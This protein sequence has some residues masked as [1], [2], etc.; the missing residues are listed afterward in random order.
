[1]IGKAFAYRTVAV[2]LLAAIAGCGGGDGPRSYTVTA[3]AGPGGSVSP[4]SATVPEGASTSIAIALNEGYEIAEVTGCGGTLSQTTYTTA[5]VISACSISAIFR[6]KR[7]AVTAT[8]N[9]GGSIIPASAMIEHGSRATF[10][11]AAQVGHEVVN[12]AGCGGTLSGLT[13]TTGILTGPCTVTVEYRRIPLFS[14]AATLLPDL[15]DHYLS[16]CANRTQGPLELKRDQPNM[17][18]GT[19]ANFSGHK[20]G[21]KDLAFTMW[22]G[23]PGGMEISGPTPNGGVVFQQDKNGNFSDATRKMF[24]VD[25][26]ET[27]EGVA[28]KPVVWDANGDGYDEVVWPVQGE[29]GRA[30][31]PV[32]RRF[33]FLTSQAGGLYERTLKGSLKENAGWVTLYPNEIGSF[34]V[35]TTDTVW[36]WSS[37]WQESAGFSWYKIGTTFLAR[38]AGEARSTL[39]TRPSGPTL[40][41]GPSIGLWRHDATTGWRETHFF[42]F[43][44]RSVPFITWRK[45]QGTIDLF[46]IDGRQYIYGNFERNCELSDT[47]AGE[48]RLF[49]LF[50]ASRLDLPYQEGSTLI[51]GQGTT[52]VVIPVL[53]DLSDGRLSRVSAVFKGWDEEVAPFDLACDDLDGDGNRD[54]LIFPGDDVKER[55]RP[56]VY[57]NISKDSFAAVDRSFFPTPIP[58]MRFATALYQDIDGDGFRDLVYWPLNINRIVAGQSLR[59]PLHKGRRNVSRDDL[60]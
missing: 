31:Q 50:N 28:W 6:L 55:A 34:D 43:P 32:Y 11:L 1:M 44:S 19:V 25:L 52:S 30:Q 24:G 21:R 59:F 54:V 38:R 23:V 9:T 41:R 27:A 12:A 4:T 36:R 20:D 60:R 35:A 57:L 5:P 18:S 40:D 13:Y 15:A 51:E 46:T 17:Q 3:T 29:D 2:T 33:V 56:H 49:A 26:I 8:A 48:R 39:G 10:T 22:C 16:L 58:E 37:G 45:E 47:A 14:S 53:F 42:G 7:Y